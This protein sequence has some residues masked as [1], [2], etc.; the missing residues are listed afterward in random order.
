MAFATQSWEEFERHTTAAIELSPDD[1]R[2][3]ILTVARDYREAAM[4]DD[5]PAREAAFAKAL[6]LVKAQPDN[7]I[8]QEIEIDGYVRNAA[9]SDALGT[10]DRVL[11][12]NPENRNMYNIRLSILARLEENTDIETQLRD[13]VTR[14][15]EDDAVKQT[16]IRFYMSREES[17]KV[18]AF[19]REIADPS[20]EEPGLYLSL[21]QFVGELCGQDAMLAEL[22]RS[23]P[24]FPIPRSTVRCVR[25]LGS[26]RASALKRLQPCKRS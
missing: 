20:A 13:M 8:L 23:S 3:Q 25:V 5:N 16:L 18:E 7:A 12:K 11:E 10:I 4:D 1:P 24:N 14:F 15:P 2:V 22:D 26:N 9:Y 19:L 21:L 17:D 6:A